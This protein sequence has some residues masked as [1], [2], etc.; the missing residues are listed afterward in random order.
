MKDLA[1]VM[2]QTVRRMWWSGFLWGWIT[3]GLL[4]AG[5]FLLHGCALGPQLDGETHWAGPTSTPNSRTLEGMR[6]NRQGLNALLDECI[7]QGFIVEPAAARLKA[8]VRHS[9][10]LLESPTTRQEAAQQL[11]ELDE[12][13]ETSC[14]L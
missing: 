6:L 10:L 1:W 9:L 2:T 7:A 8:Q 13:I 5:F 3:M 11:D 14:G 4:I 12:E